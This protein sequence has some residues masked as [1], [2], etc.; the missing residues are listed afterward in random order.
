MLE[1]KVLGIPIMLMCYAGAIDCTGVGVVMVVVMLSIVIIGLVAVKC[2]LFSVVV[3]Y[4]C[5]FIF[6]AP[7]SHSK[8]L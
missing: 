4:C 3:C 6:T 5:W 2:I 1:P 7:A 8:M